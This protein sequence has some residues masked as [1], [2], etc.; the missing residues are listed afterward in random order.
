MWKLN[1]KLPNNQW[2]KDEIKRV[3]KKKK[4]KTNKNRNTAF[5]NLQDATQIMQ[6]EIYSDKCL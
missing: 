2:V 4:L 5:Q 3:I 1:N 6:K